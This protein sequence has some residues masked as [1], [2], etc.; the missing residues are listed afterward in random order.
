MDTCG[1]SCQLQAQVIIPEPQPAY[2]LR[3]AQDPPP[4]TAA[5]DAMAEQDYFAIGGFLEIPSKGFLW[6]SEKWSVRDLSFTGLELSDKAQSY[7]ASFEALA[8]IALLHVLTA[9]LPGGRMRVRIKSWSDNTGAESAS[10]RLYTN[11][12]PLNMFV[13]RLSLFSC[14]SGVSLDVSH[15]PGELNED[16]GMLSRWS[17]KASELPDRFPPS[18]RIPLNLEQL[19]FRRQA[20]TLWPSEVHLPRRIPMNDFFM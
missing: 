14:Y 18:W 5:A 16:A 3:W 9:A 20:V 10:N 8:Q 4:A 13:Q 17:G 11:K 6:F 7:I 1:R 2:W 12:C 19:R 15:I